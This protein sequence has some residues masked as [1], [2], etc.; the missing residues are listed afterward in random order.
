MNKITRISL[1]YLSAFAC[2]ISI[3]GCGTDNA[4]NTTDKPLDSCYY[5]TYTLNNN[6]IELI[7]TATGSY[8]PLFS[9]FCNGCGLSIS[10]TFFMDG[11]N[12]STNTPM[13]ILWADFDCDS[14]SNFQQA[15]NTIIN[16]TAFLN[17][18]NQTRNNIE[19]NIYLERYGTPSQGRD[20]YSVSSYPRLI[21]DSS[22]F[23]YMIFNRIT[24]RGFVYLDE[25]LQLSNAGTIH[26]LLVAEGTFNFIIT[27]YTV[28]WSPD[29]N[30]TS[31]WSGDFIL[32]NGKFRLPIILN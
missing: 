23:N 7:D 5:M 28:T 32:R 25:N 4:V 13:P 27:R 12:N 29:G 10:P 8:L 20:A 21:T 26:K 9:S 14:S 2:F 3:S 22:R 24:E 15:L 1:F 30:H 16:D 18:R 6:N 31:V 17:I 11:Q 19:Y